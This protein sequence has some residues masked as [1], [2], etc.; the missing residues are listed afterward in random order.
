[1]TCNETK[2]EEEVVQRGDHLQNHVPPVI[3]KEDATALSKHDFRGITLFW[4]V[5]TAEYGP[6]IKSQ[7]ASRNYR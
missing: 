3:G 5:H 2:E 6:F 1:M 7:L 4:V